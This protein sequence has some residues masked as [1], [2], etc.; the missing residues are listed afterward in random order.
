MLILIKGVSIITLIMGLLAG[1]IGVFQVF[2]ST[3]NAG[4]DDYLKLLFGLLLIVTGLYY[5]F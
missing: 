1:S 2:V 3:K 5:L 4:I